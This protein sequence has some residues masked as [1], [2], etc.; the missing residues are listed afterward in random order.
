M[1]LYQLGISYVLFQI[2][3]ESSFRCLTLLVFSQS[4]WEN[5]EQISQA[6]LKDSVVCVQILWLHPTIAHFGRPSCTQLYTNFGQTSLQWVIEYAEN[7]KDLHGSK[8]CSEVWALLCNPCQRLERNQF[9]KY[10]ANM[11]SFQDYLWRDL[12]NQGDVSFNVV[13]G[14]SQC[15]GFGE[16]WLFTN[17][18]VFFNIILKAVASPPTHKHTL[19]SCFHSLCS[20]NVTQCN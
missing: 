1:E 2:S 6:A 19:P 5:E 9:R 12:F 17:C 7:I 14:K 3:N 15:V 16:I 10:H 13:F 4:S 8:E 18:A 11:P 20:V